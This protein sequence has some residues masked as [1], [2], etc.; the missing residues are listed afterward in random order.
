MDFTIVELMNYI[1]DEEHFTKY[2]VPIESLTILDKPDDFSWYVHVKAK[3][4]FVVSARDFINYSFIHT[5]DPNSEF[6]MVIVF[7]IDKPIGP[8]PAENK[9]VVRANMAVGGWIFRKISD[10]RTHVSYL[11]LSDMRGSIPKFALSLGA[12]QIT[13]SL[14]KLIT[15]MTA[16]KADG[17]LSSEF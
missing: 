6:Q 5:R 15:L 13:Q 2:N 4:M 14:E 11:S 7:S 12:G 16:A 17:T 8:D 3:G 1:G 10:T 9:G